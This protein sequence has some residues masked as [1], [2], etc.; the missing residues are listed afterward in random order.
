MLNWLR[1]FNIF[2]FLDSCNY[3]MAPHR[4]DCL[5]AA[6]AREIL[7]LH[8][9]EGLSSLVNREGEWKFG[10]LS[11]RLKN[12]V[13]HLTPSHIDPIGFADACFFIPQVVVGIVENE[14]TIWAADP[15][16][17]WQAIQ[18]Q[19]V[20][21]ALSMQVALQETV[22]RETYIRTVQQLQQH[23]RR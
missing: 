16:A 15:E 17:I 2:C 10:H 13:H 8:S 9:H 11:Y 14:V 21:P 5:V 4:Y 1:R 7:S 23:I 3:E 19:P 18:K 12:A 22:D 6:G 20:S